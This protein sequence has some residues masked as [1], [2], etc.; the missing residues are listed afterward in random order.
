MSPLKIS[1]IHSVTSQGP[2]CGQSLLRVGQHL[3]SLKRIVK[4]YFML[5]VNDGWQCEMSNDGIRTITVITL[6]LE[7]SLLE[8]VEVLL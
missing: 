8:T 3:V 2:I 5:N 6:I 7:I 4:T 1:I